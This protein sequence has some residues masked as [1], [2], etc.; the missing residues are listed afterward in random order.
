MRIE[1][2]TI[3]LDDQRAALAFYTGVLGFVK[4]HDIQLGNDF[5]LTVVSQIRQTGRNC[6]SNRAVIPR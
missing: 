1:L 3:F 6:C 2:T 5:W 4:L